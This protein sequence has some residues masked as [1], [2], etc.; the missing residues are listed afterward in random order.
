[1]LVRR[2]P[3]LF[4]IERPLREFFGD[5][6]FFRPV[7]ARERTGVMPLDVW[8]METKYSIA[9]EIPGAK[10]EDISVSI[11]GNRVTISAELKREV[12]V[13]QQ[14]V[15]PLLQERYCGTLTRTVELGL[16]I[17]ESGAKAHYENGVLML[18]LPKSKDALPKRL[19]I[20]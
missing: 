4:D 12:D 20:H 6:E 1:M 8:E 15:Q 14:G 7:R 11:D 17:D 9:A 5:M 19:T 3:F 16:P 13:Q 2:D 18:D 10:K